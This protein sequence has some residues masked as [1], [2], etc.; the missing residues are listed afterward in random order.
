[1][2]AAVCQL[3]QLFDRLHLRVLPQL[4]NP[5]PE[6]AS[7]RQDD[8]VNVSKFICGCMDVLLGANT[9]EQNQMSD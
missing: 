4:A 9:D 2:E 7:R 5:H 8:L 6:A 1:M 3:A